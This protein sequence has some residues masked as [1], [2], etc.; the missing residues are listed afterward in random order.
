[1]ALFQILAIDISVIL[2]SMLF[3]K[4]KKKKTISKDK[5]KWF[6][7]VSTPPPPPLEVPIFLPVMLVRLVKFCVTFSVLNLRWCETWGTLPFD[8][9]WYCIILT[10]NFS[11]FKVPYVKWLNYTIYC[12]GAIIWLPKTTLKTGLRG[13]ISNAIKDLSVSS[14]SPIGFEVEWHS[15]QPDKWYQSQGHGFESRECHC[16]GRIVR[17]TT[18]WLHTTTLRSCFEHTQLHYHI[19]SEIVTCPLLQQP[20]FKAFGYVLS[21]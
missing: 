4:K 12:W 2:I 20:H 6:V 17:G 15:S 1:M 14:L 21:S 10:C 13:V 16:E 11:S 7:F 5:R 18:I 19:F 9:L 3:P 8:S